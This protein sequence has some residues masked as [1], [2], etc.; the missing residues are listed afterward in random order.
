V[1]PGDLVWFS[2]EVDTSGNR[3]KCD[4]GLLIKYEKWEKIAYILYMGKIRKVHACYA[5]KAGKKYRDNIHP[6]NEGKT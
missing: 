2:T 6:R 1:K 3:I 5:E 4:L